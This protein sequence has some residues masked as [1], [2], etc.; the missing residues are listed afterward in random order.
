MHGGEGWVRQG[1]HAWWGRGMHGSGHM[2]GR[3]VR[4]WLGVCMVGGYA[5][6]GGMRGMGACVAGG[7]H[8]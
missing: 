8:S 7:M 1:G 6:Q 2:H 4:A 5:W 3:G